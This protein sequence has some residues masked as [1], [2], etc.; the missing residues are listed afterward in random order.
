LLSHL[1]IPAE[2]GVMVALLNRVTTIAVGSAMGIWGGF[3]LGLNPLRREW[4]KR[5]KGGA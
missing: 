5:V 1:G 3:A 2:V 4:M